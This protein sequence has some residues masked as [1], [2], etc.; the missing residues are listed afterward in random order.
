MNYCWSLTFY[1][2]YWLPRADIRVAAVLTRNISKSKMLNDTLKD[3]A[4]IKKNFKGLNGSLAWFFV[5]RYDKWIIKWMKYKS[6][7]IDIP[8]ANDS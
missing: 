7:N 1:T 3:N 6:K 4:C 2:C 5:M 8:F